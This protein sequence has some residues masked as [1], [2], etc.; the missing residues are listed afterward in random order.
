[1]EWFQ[2][3]VRIEQKLFDGAPVAHDGAIEPDLSRPGHGLEFKW[4]D[5][6]SFHVNGVAN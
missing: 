4:E 2:D 6:E 1:M 5:A 3:H